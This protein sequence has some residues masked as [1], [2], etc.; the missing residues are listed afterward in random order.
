MKTN[1]GIS[2]KNRKSVIGILNITLSDEFVLY[3]KTLNYH[4]NMTGPNF[5]ELHEFL[6]EQYKELI[7]TIDEMA[8]RVRQ[9]DGKSFGTLTE[10]LKAARLKETPAQTLGFKQMLT[11]L[12]SDH[13]SLIVCLRESV[14]ACE[15]E[16]DDIGT[17]DFL[18]GV[19][20]QHEKMAWMIRSYLE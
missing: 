9:L 7:V 2:D 13:E 14:R 4:W 17:S 16:Y 10:F 8:E 12:L 20:K 3:T 5:A 18:T 11:N 19:M 15:E 1:I 6:E